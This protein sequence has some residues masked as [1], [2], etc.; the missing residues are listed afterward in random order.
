M[1]TP[2]IGGP[3][4]RTLDSPEAIGQALHQLLES[5]RYE[6]LSALPDGGLYDVEVLRS[7]WDYDVEL[8]DR[9]VDVRVIYP[10]SAAR[11]PAVLEYLAQFA[12]RGAKVRVLGSVSNRMVIADRARAI[13]PERPDLSGQTG[14]ALLVGGPVL[15]RALYTE[16][17]ELWR[18]SLPVGFSTG[19]L[20]VELVR[21]TL[22][23]MA[24]GMTDEAV[25]RKYSWSLRTYRRRVAAVLEL[26]GTTSRFEAGVLARTQGWI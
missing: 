10:A 20:D 3:P 1:P 18:A 16:F 21:E 19:G 11:S 4:V 25:C 6:W 7:S 13:T 2:T 23:A 5:A 26:L 9:G 8:L 24:E 14:A 12:A 22:K 17:L 15:V